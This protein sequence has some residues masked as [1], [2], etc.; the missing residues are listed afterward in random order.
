MA[1]AL[2]EAAARG[3]RFQGTPECQGMKSPAGAQGRLR[4]SSA[5][6]RVRPRL[7]TFETRTSAVALRSAFDAALVAK[8]ATDHVLRARRK[9]PDAGRD[10]RG[11]VGEASEGVTC[12]ILKPPSAISLLNPSKF[13]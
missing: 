5:R 8:L 12:S 9:A 2:F 6:A 1:G 7:S 3:G 4:S 10:S 11:E 13:T